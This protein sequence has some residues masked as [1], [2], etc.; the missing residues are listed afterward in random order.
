M[1][2]IVRPALQMTTV[3]FRQHTIARI[4][5][6]WPSPVGASLGCAGR[7]VVVG[8][9]SPALQLLSFSFGSIGTRHE[10]IL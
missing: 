9:V 1:A 5:R 3:G 4:I 6:W 2:D 7:R 10:G 8:L